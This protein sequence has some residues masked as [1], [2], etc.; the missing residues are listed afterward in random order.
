[1]NHFF[2]NP[3]SQAYRNSL[4]HEIASHILK[5]IF[6]GELIQGTRLIESDIAKELNVSNIPVREAFYILQNTGII[7]RL[8]RKGVRV[9]SV[10]EQEIKDYTDALIELYRIGI[11]YSESKWDDD[12]RNNLRKYLQEANEKLIEKDIVNYV[13]KCEEICSYLFIV[14]ENKA[15]LRFYSEITYI[16]T[17]Y[18]QTTWNNL[19]KIQ[20][21]HCYLEGLVN[22]LINSNFKQAIIEYERLVR[23]SLTI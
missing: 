22:S 5:K 12:K 11:D 17:A 10:S 9:I 6:T 7:E 14:A 15:F 8:P 1:M 3:I 20:S 21:C 19:E 2:F 23:E 18:C 13:L 16:T 4:P